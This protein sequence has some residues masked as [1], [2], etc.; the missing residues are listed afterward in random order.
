MRMVFSFLLIFGTIVV[1][2]SSYAQSCVTGKATRS[3]LQLWQ[4]HAAYS[5]AQWDSLFAGLHQHGFTEIIVQWSTYGQ[6]SYLAD[7][8]PGRETAE[9]LPALMA[10]ARRAKCK[11]W[12]GLHYD[13]EFWQRI[14]KNSEVSAYLNKRLRFFE[15]SLPLLLKLV[16]TTDPAGDTVAGWYIA[17]E[18]DDRNW[19]SSQRQILLLNYLAAISSR[20]HTS[21]PRLPILISG[22]VNGTMTPTAWSALVK[23]VLMDTAIQTFLLQDAI[24]TG[25]MTVARLQP[26]LQVLL[27]TLPDPAGR[28]SLIVEIFSMGNG[29]EEHTQP[30]PFD[31][32][33][34][35]LTS[36]ASFS[37][38]P[39]TIFSAPDHLLDTT[40]PGVMTL[41]KQW[42]NERTDCPGIGP[43][44]RGVTQGALLLLEGQSISADK[45]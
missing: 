26:Y 20:L 31:R 39:L 33:V 1:S 3:F 35:Q 42:L 32:I 19:Q 43:S 17:D 44:A 30:G 23:R 12:L 10:A 8:R 7:G 14:E 28:F 4:A 2:L 45:Q 18:I 38:S 29:G 36:A 9:C 25:K 11:L 22:F 6:V 16:T 40:K 27:Q 41:S 13:P 21:T 34:E 24:G 15:E 37:R 5:P